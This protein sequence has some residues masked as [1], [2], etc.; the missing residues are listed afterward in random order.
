MAELGRGQG[1]RVVDLG[2]YPGTGEATFTVTG[3]DGIVAGAS[4]RA[5]VTPTATDDHTADEHKVDPPRAYPGAITA[6]SGFTLG[7]VATQLGQ[8][9]KWSVG[10]EW[11]NP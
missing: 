8:W 6:G 1:V 5:W 11:V 4:V 3:Q 7:L 2:A 9:G 10:F